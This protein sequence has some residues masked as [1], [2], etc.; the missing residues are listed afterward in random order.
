M[1]ADA[2]FTFR[3]ITLREPL[4]HELVPFLER[5]HQHDDLTLRPARVARVQILLAYASRNALH[6]LLVDIS[7]QSVLQ[8][9]HLVGKH[10]FID[11][12]YMQEVEAVCKA[13]A[14]VHDKLKSLDLPPEAEVVIEAWAYATD[15]ENDMRERTTMVSLQLSFF[16]LANPQRQVLVLPTPQRQSGCQ[17]LCLSTQHLC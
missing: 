8:R 16:L 14:V 4:K 3:F 7:S 5:E 13:D 17:L 2:D 15:G 12:A 9:K 10:A 1:V 6:E 11:S